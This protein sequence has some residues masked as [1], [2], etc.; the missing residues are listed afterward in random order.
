M[1][2]ARSKKNG[3]NRGLIGVRLLSE[4]MQIEVVR[5]GLVINAMHF[6]AQVWSLWALSKQCFNCSQWGHTQVSSGRTSKCTGAHQTR[7]SP[8]KRVSCANCGREYRSWQ[9]EACWT[10]YAY[11]ES[12]EKARIELSSST[13]DIWN[14]NP[15]KCVNAN[16][17]NDWRSGTHLGHP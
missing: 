13:T 11:K 14:E 1:E 12:V 9:K 7:D 8:R 17:W 5:N 6:T 3:R 10:Y 16:K 4:A 15:H 2:H